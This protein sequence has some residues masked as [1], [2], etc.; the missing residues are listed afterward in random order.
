MKFSDDAALLSLLQGAESD[1]GCAL[2]AFVEWCDKNFLDLNVSKTKELVID[3]RKNKVNPTHSIIHGEDVDIVDSYKYLGT[4][5]DSHLK[6]DVNTE[7]IVKRSQ[8][9]IHLLRKINSFG[10][11][12]S[13]LCTVYLS[14]IESL[15]TFLFICWFNRL[16]MK[17]RNCLNNIVKVCSKIIG[18]QQSNLNSLW[19]KRVLQKAKNIINHNQILSSEFTLLPSGRRYL[20]PH[21][22]TNRYSKS[23]IPSAIKL[24]NAE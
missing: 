8:Q 20:P 18:A 7:S 14:Y 2:P 9:R 11:S 12:R 13:I 21:R 1:H 4:V 22:K 24:L 10:V 16:S 23:F 6:F 5:F 15:L 17:D 19:E 3:F